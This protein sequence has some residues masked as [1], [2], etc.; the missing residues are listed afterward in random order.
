MPHALLVLGAEGTGGLSFGLAMAQFLFC[1]NQGAQDSCGICAGCS[2]ASKLQHADL[3]LSFPSFKPKPTEAALSRHY[4]Q[5]FRGFVKQTPYG[6]SF[7]WLQHIEAENKQG[8]ISADECRE[9]INSLNLRSYE[10]GNKVLVMWRPEYLGKEG[11][12]LLKLIEEPPLNTFIIMVAE[13]SDEILSTIKSR[14][15]TLRLAPLSVK[16]ISE[17]LITRSQMDQVK[18]VRIANLAA[19]SYTEA[20]KLS[21]SAENEL[22]QPVRQLF[23]A[24][25]NKKTG[26]GVEISKLV[27][28]YAKSG[29][30][31][32]KN[33]LLYVIK[34]LE[35]ACRKKFVPAGIVGLPE[36]ET[37]LVVFLSS[38]LGLDSFVQMLD[39]VNTTIYHIERNAHSKT[40]LHAMAIRLHYIVNNKPLPGYRT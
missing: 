7:D 9:I 40:Q 26:G 24:L 4:I 38:N 36:E 2:K 3:H 20:L 14:T 1:E 35:H 23:L 39:T 18:A 37:K 31:Q 5:D 25:F 27:E 6:T 34:L 13:Q 11:N 17:A 8:N 32:Q 22:F 15:Q 16:E 29:R 28:E 21:R 12:I 19:G 33:M 10:G 30:E